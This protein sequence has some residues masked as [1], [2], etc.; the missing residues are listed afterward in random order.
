MLHH[1]PATVQLLKTNTSATLHFL[2]SATTSKSYKVHPLIETP[3]RC[4]ATVVALRVAARSRGACFE[5]SCDRQKELQKQHTKQTAADYLQSSEKT[6]LGN[7]AVFT[8]NM[9]QIKN[10]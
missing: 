5:A 7:C 1:A 2:A 9:R 3:V 10:V 6:N 4:T 8:L